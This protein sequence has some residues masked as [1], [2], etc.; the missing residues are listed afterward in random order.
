M[1]RTDLA[2]LLRRLRETPV[3]GQ[4]LAQALRISRPA[5][6]KQIR[7]LQTAGIPIGIHR[8]RGYFL[9]SRAD[10]S[11]M[12]LAFRGPLA[13]W[14]QPHHA[15]HVGSTQT[16]ARQAAVQSV[17]EGHLWTAETQGQGRGR[18]GRSWVSGYGGLWF[19]LVLRPE[20]PAARSA[21]LGLLAA[22]SIAEAL[23]AQGVTAVRV[24]WPNDVMVPIRGQWRKLAGVLTEMSGEADRTEWAVLGVGINV[25]NDLPPGLEETACR[26]AD[27]GPVGLRDRAQLLQNVLGQFLGRYRLWRRKGFDALRDEYWRRFWR[28][29]EPLTLKTATGEIRGR[30]VRVDGSGAIILESGGEIRPIFEGE[31]IR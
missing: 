5:V 4:R 19:S 21:T 26:L 11:L 14:A 1:T 25:W 3:S 17:P 12:R 30:A 18:L 15:V 10:H 29:R 22:L 31:I 16:L 20:A 2:P 28:P 6:W 9:K 24:K 13:L 23:E 7:A 27:C 8:K